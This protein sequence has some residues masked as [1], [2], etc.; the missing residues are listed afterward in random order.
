MEQVID[1]LGFIKIKNF[2]RKTT[3][4]KGDQ[5]HI[6]KKYLQKI[7]LIKDFTQNRQRTLKT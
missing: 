7:D 1:K 2:M 4:R 5:P 3:S 6:G